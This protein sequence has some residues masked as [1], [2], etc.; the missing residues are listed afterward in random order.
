M[1]NWLIYYREVLFG[2]SLSDLINNKKIDENPATN[3]EEMKPSEKQ[4][5]K[6]RLDLGA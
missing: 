5:E 1:V 2:K 3:S 6:H 4:F